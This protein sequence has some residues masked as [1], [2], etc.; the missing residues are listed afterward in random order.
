MLPGHPVLTLPAWDCLPYDRVSPNGVT[1][2][3]RMTTL[4]ALTSEATKGAIVLTAVNALIQK[5]PPRDVVAG[6]SFSAAAGQVVDSE[7]LIAWAANNGYLRVPTVRESG[8]YAVRGGLVD[9]FPASAETPLRFDF[10]GKPARDRSA[11]SIPTRQRTTGT[12]KRDRAAPMSEVLLN[13]ETIRRFRAALHRDLR[14]QHRRR[15]AL[16]ARSAPASAIPGIEHW[17]PFFYEHLDRLADYAGDAPFVF[18]DQAREA[19]ADRQTQIEDYYEAREAGAD[20]PS[21]SRRPGRPTSRCQ[22]ELLYEVDAA[23]LSRSAG[24]SVIQLSPFMRAR[25]KARGRCRRPHRAELRGRAAGADVNL[26]EAVVDRLLA[27]QQQA[28]AAPIIACWTEGSRDRMAQVLERPRADA[29]RAWPRTGAT[30]KPPVAATTALVVLPLETGFET[31]D[32]L[33][34]SE[35]DILG[36]RLLRPQRKK[37]ASRRADRGGQPRCRRSRGPCRS[38]HRPLPRAQG[39][40]GRRARRTTASRSNTPATPSSTCRSK[41][42]SC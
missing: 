37:K 8:E 40:R 35:Q 26:F 15:S 29:I 41:T 34:L 13:E 9:L 18:D 28:A 21:R 22:P 25:T 36:E 12:L 11:P 31:D 17:L 30:P 27:E 38:R 19:F 2:A 23:S 4:A 14:R 20:A 24:A 5:L 7:K 39:D 1:I 33:V 3:A 16:C 6:M 32:L 10:F 42:S